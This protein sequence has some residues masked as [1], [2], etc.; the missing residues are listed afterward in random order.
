MCKSSFAIFR[1]GCHSEGSYDQ[2]TTVST[3]PTDW[4]PFYNHVCRAYMWGW[5]GV[6]GMCVCVCVNKVSKLVFYTQST[7]TVIS[8]RVC[9]QRQNAF[10]FFDLI[11]FTS[12]LCILCQPVCNT[13]AFGSD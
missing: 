9:K 3:V 10:Y 4:L 8:G 5:G 2:I 7:G 13:G 12:V 6:G 1:G 11:K